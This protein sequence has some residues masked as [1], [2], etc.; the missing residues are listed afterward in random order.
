M[1]AT[2]I[3]RNEF[4]HRQSDTCFSQLYAASHAHL[5]LPQMHLC[6]G[7]PGLELALTDI[8]RVRHSKW[9]TLLQ[10]SQVT[11]T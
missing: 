5:M 2:N 10:L 7:W 1:S 9:L 4:K 3:L 6:G 8:N 11:K